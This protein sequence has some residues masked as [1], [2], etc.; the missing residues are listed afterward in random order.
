M[1]ALAALARRTRRCGYPAAMVLLRSLLLALLAFAAAGPSCFTVMLWA[2]DSITGSRPS[3]P[4]YRNVSESRAEGFAEIDE[5]PRLWLV[6]PAGAME[7]FGIVEAFDA[8]GV[9]FGAAGRRDEVWMRGLLQAH[10][11]DP[12]AWPLRVVGIARG[13]ERRWFLV[14]G[15]A[16]ARSRRTEMVEQVLDEQGVRLDPHFVAAP[17]ADDGVAIGAVDLARMDYVAGSG[18]W[19]ETAGRVLVTPPMLVVDAVLLPFEVVVLLAWLF[20]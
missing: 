18:G 8:R 19:Q 4:G 10:A 20:S 5:Q 11:E 7:H 3:A 14:G 13:G 2:G 9:G 12:D 17:I 1:A 6:L 16:V 15:E